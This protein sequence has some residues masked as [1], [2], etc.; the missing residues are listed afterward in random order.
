MATRSETNCEKGAKSQKGKEDM[1]NDNIF[2]ESFLC[3]EYPSYNIWPRNYKHLLHL[4]D[5]SSGVAPATLLPLHDLCVRAICQYL[6]DNGHSSSVCCDISDSSVSVLNTLPLPNKLKCQIA[7]EIDRNVMFHFE[8]YV[9]PPDFD[10]GQKVGSLK[11][12]GGYSWTTRFGLRT[13]SWKFEIL[14]GVFLDHRI[15][16]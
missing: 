6:Y 7:E 5:L 15:W 1:C 9:E 13:K 11:F 8:K 2:G 12:L 14:G 3:E 16:T 10:L 4:C